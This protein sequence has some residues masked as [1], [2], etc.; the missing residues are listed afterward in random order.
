MAEWDVE[1]WLSEVATDTSY[2]EEVLPLLIDLL[3]PAPERR[4]L[5][6]GCGEG[7][8]MR[9]LAA[10]GSRIVGTDLSH[11]LL[12]VA[13]AAG[14]VVQARL[15]ELGWIA[16]RAFDGVYLMLV[17]EHIEDAPTLFAQ[18]ARIVRPGGVLVVVA[19][20][21][22]FTAPGAGPLI[23]ADD[24]EVTW[25]WGPYLEERSSLE[26]GGAGNVTVYHRP[27]GALLTAAASAGWVLRRLE[28]RGYGEAARRRDPVLANQK[29]LPRLLGVRWV[30]SSG[31]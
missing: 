15:P 14:P 12:Q 6:A 4:Y 16:D 23:D 1:W 31:P 26:P 7:Q 17:V 5:D 9:V 18:A 21:P 2:R 11:P 20:H 29:H 24:G 22:A 25:R 28:E 27:L 8:G 10:Y 30:R 13:A 19:N 3:E